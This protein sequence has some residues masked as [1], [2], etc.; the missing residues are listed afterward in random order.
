SNAF[1]KPYSAIEDVRLFWG[2]PESQLDNAPRRNSTS[3]LTSSS[4]VIVSE[5]P[6]ENTPAVEILYRGEDVFSLVSNLAD[7]I[8]ASG[9]ID[10]DIVVIGI[11]DGG[12]ALGNLLRRLLEK[13]SGHSLPYGTIETS[14]HRDD[15]GRRPIPMEVQSTEIPVNIDGRP[16]LLVDDVIASGRTIRAAMN[17]LFDQG[18]PADIQLAILF[19]RGGRKLPVQPD[20]LAEKI[21]VAP[22]RSLEVKVDEE[23]P[24]RHQ[25]ELHP[26]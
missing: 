18:R 1:Q 12:I 5:S 23:D 19:D 20:F 22:N 14:F 24:S 21:T 16:I 15:I 10:P 3:R 11:A 4:I 2:I 8:L 17:E 7:Q 6:E 13:H 26:R 25:I 9:E